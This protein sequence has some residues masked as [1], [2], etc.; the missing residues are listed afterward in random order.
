MDAL[1]GSDSDEDDE[2][3][4]GKADSQHDV[5]IAL[6]RLRPSV[7][8]RE[9]GL[10][11]VLHRV[12]AVIGAKDE[13]LSG[14][15][16]RSG[17]VFTWYASLTEAVPGGEVDV[18]V[19]LSEVQL[20]TS[21]AAS[22]TALVIA[23]GTFIYALAADLQAHSLQFP[24]EEWISVRSTELRKR[25]VAC[26]PQGAI[27]WGAM[28]TSA[29]L[30]SER[31]L[32]EE[33]AV[34]LSVAERR[35]R[36]LSDES[37]RR[38]SEALRKHGLCVLCGLFPAKEVL[39]WG[40]AAREDMMHILATLRKSKGIDLLQPGTGPRIE[41]FHELSMREALRCDIRNGPKMYAAAAS[42]DHGEGMP[43]LRHH[44]AVLAV[45]TPVMNPAGDP[46]EAKGNWGRW[47]FEGAGP[48]SGPPPPT[49]GKVAA[50]MSLPGCADQTIHADTAHLYVHT[51][52]PGHYYN[53]F[54]PAVSRVDGSADLSVG[55]TAFVCGTHQ[56]AL[57]A[58]V[59]VQEGGQQALNERLVRPHLR[60]GDGL[61][62]DCRILHFGLAN[63][64][65]KPAEDEGMAGNEKEKEKE[66][67]REKEEVDEGN[68]ISGV[69]RTLL[70]INY[71][72]SWFVDPKNWNDKEKLF[73]T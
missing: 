10:E 59:M 36:V 9:E 12:V 67:E 55:Q 19:L 8:K 20:T 41:N 43:D 18:L 5:W 48:E 44:P 47:N 73:E 42:A 71:T 63:Q 6:M 50:V 54:L 40:A 16:T 38:A 70:Y 24:S 25:S 69:M 34:P 49:A 26:N 14:R 21:D 52:L 3:R 37:Q 11:T 15:L 27:Y 57:S 66:K 60:A 65:G 61:L 39:Q 1:F 2:G 29:Q 46:E 68:D 45:L 64:S 13:S 17:F 51:Q 32:L 62:F 4:D 23:G 33:V 30:D 35:L 28:S 56:L 53:L 58:K 22:V 31:A 72:Q 7:K